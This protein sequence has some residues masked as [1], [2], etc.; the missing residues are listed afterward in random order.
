MFWVFTSTLRT[1]RKTLRT[2]NMKYS[3]WSTDDKSTVIQPLLCFPAS[4][5]LQ[6]KTRCL[7]G[8]NDKHSSRCLL[9][10]LHIWRTSD[11]Y[12]LKCL[13]PGQRL[14]HF[15]QQPRVPCSQNHSGVSA[16]NYSMKVFAMTH[17]KAK[18]HL[19]FFFW[20]S[21]YIWNGINDMRT[22]F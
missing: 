19:I 16:L 2:L 6:T 13:T 9:T 5:L 8:G 3:S 17:S 15:L 11:C 21:F 1:E 12:T 22:K 18:K 4:V 20:N 10:L 7:G 14:T